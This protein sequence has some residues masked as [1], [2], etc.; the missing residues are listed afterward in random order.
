M[1]S[2][3]PANPRC[4]VGR[5]SKGGGGMSLWCVVLICSWQRQLADRPSLG[6]SPSVGGGAHRPLT[7]LCPSSASVAYLY[8]STSLSYPVVGCAKR[9]G[10]GVDL[11]RVWRHFSSSSP[12]HSEQFGCPQVRGIK[13]PSTIPHA[14][15]TMGDNVGAHW[16]VLCPG[17][18]RPTKRSGRV[19]DSSLFTIAGDWG[20]LKGG[21]GSGP[22]RTP[23]L[24]LCLPPRS[25]TRGLLFP[26]RS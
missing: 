10:G 12:F 1:F 26:E 24:P 5:G 13:S 16:G 2:S 9:G 20:V 3:I 21:G 8:L 18:K 11:F 7:P 22:T 23:P 6:P 19:G 25:A 17:P 4:S 14:W 15:G